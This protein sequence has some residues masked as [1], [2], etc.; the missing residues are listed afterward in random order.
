[1][2][3][4]INVTTYTSK[5]TGAAYTLT[6]TET[7]E[8][9]KT[10]YVLTSREDDT[11]VIRT[12]ESVLKRWYK[13]EIVVDFTEV[14]EPETKK[15]EA[16]KAKKTRKPRAKTYEEQKWGLVHSRMDLDTFCNL[17]DVVSLEY[18]SKDKIVFLG[19]GDKIV[20]RRGWKNEITGSVWF[21][22]KNAEFE[23]TDADYDG[24]VYIPEL[25]DEENNWEEEA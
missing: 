6:T 14:E 18:D 15:S 25:D 2:K 9:G 13:K 24:G 19:V 17:M 12:T 1:M 16:P 8:A 21:R 10:I 4:A 7:N 3:T 22:Y 23:I 11:D 20:K 5:K